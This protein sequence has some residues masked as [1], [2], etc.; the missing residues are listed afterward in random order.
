L[1]LFKVWV[2]CFKSDERSRVISEV[3]LKIYL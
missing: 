2:P 1:I 3:L